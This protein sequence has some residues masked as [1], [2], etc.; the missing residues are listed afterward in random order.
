MIE[1]K[2]GI[3]TFTCDMTGCT[4][5]LMRPVQEG[6]DEFLKRRHWHNNPEGR[7]ICDD[8]TPELKW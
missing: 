7:L 8:H 5:T 3:T 6:D 1:R 2:D 4:K